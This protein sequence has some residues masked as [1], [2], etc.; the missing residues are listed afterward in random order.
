M[1]L[2]ELEEETDVLQS[3]EYQTALANLVRALGE[4]GRHFAVCNDDADDCHD[5]MTLMWWHDTDVMA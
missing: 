1:V 4:Q 3:P 5:G 2:A